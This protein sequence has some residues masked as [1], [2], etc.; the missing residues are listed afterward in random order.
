[1]YLFNK[2]AFLCLIT[3]N[4]FNFKAVITFIKQQ[5]NWLFFTG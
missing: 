3:G 2:T 1:M 5:K 4:P